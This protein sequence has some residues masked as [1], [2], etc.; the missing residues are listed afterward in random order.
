[1]SAVGRLRA[2][3]LQ[4]AP[5]RS[6]SALYGMQYMHA[7]H[8]TALDG[9]AYTTGRQARCGGW[10][11]AYTQAVCMPVCR[12]CPGQLRY[13]AGV[14]RATSVP[15]NST[16]MQT[17]TASVVVLPEATEV[18]HGL[19]KAPKTAH[20]MLCPRSYQFGTAA[21]IR[22]P[23]TLHLTVCISQHPALGRDWGFRHG[24]QE[25]YQETKR[26]GS[27]CMCAAGEAPNTALLHMH[28]WM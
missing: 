16:K 5:S 6:N 14:H 22:A 8:L 11:R 13:E 18:S 25:L 4:L 1:M 15:F 12:L 21:N 10:K 24:G 27:C 26:S 19:Q 23:F 28:R 3:A 2:S 7:T 17:S 9:T 20:C